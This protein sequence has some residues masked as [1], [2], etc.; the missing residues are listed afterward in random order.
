V[1]GKVRVFRVAEWNSFYSVVAK[2]IK[3]KKLQG[4][5]FPLPTSGSIEK[6]QIRVNAPGLAKKK[7]PAPYARDNKRRSNAALK[8]LRAGEA[9]LQKKGS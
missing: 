7:A 2:A 3:I 8:K 5:F 1:R 6:F 9:L 4:L